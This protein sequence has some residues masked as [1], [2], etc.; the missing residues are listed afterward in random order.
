MMGGS[1]RRDIT[2]LPA[3]L[4]EQIARLQNPLDFSLSLLVSIAL[5][6]SALDAVS[7]AA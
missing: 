7:A 2:R 1:Q 5:R 3:T 6:S 4:L